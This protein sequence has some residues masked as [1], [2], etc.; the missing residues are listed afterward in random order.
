MSRTYSAVIDGRTIDLFEDWHGRRWVSL[1]S[2]A[3][4]DDEVD[5]P[6]ELEEEQALPQ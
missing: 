1:E 6:T 5:E 4:D 2:L 3:I